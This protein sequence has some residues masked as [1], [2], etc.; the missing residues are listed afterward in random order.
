MR[1]INL[2]LEPS[3]GPA[4]PRGT[5]GDPGISGQ[6]GDPGRDGRPGEP[7]HCDPSFCYQTATQVSR[8][9]YTY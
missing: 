4:G 1:D 6:H 3:R 2:F 5:Q 9:L 8:G 7:G